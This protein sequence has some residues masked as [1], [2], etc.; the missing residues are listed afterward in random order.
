VLTPPSLAAIGPWLGALVAVL[1]AGLAT[2]APAGA[3]P[4]PTAPQVISGAGTVSLGG[5]AI[6]RDGT[7]GLVFLARAGGV[8]HVYVSR[9]IG[10]SFT[11]PQQVDAA[12]TGGSTQPVI[13]AGNG[14][15]LIVAFVNGGTLYA[16][17]APASGQVFGTP[18]PIYAGAEN[19]TLS[20][21]TFGK[22]YLA[23][24]A[25]E[26]GGSDVR[27]A[28]YAS[29]RWAPVP[30]PLNAASGDDAGTGAGRP[31]V[32]AAGDGVGIVSWGERGHVYA[33][34]I[35][36]TSPSVAVE[37]LDP[38][39][40]AG[41][42]ETTAD[43]ASVSVGGDSS[44]VDIAY[45]EGLSGGGVT[46][47]RVLLSRLQAE[48]VLPAV[49]VDGLDSSPDSAGQP[50]V[51]MN[52]YGRGFATATDTANNSL[53]AETLATNGAPAGLAN[54]GS[55]PN[56]VPPY[57]A[58]APAGLIS[59]LIAWQQAAVPGAAQVLLRYAADGSTLGPDTL[60]SS[61]AQGPARADLGLFAGGD[62]EGDAAVAW[63]QGTSGSL[64]VVAAQLYVPPGSPQPTNRF[65]YTRQPQPT[66][67]WSAAR[68]EWGP[69]TYEVTL[70]GASLGQ[71]TGTSQQVP[72]PLIDGPHSWQL[73]ASNPSGE[74]RN[75]PPA[76]VFVDTTAPRLRA[77]L[78]GTPRA[79]TPLG[80]QVLPAD[81]PP[82]Q[83]G[84]SASGVRSVS[85]T[86]GDRTPETT[87]PAVG[88]LHHA[89]ARPGLYR[90]RATATD[91]ATNTTTLV[92][93]VQ[94]LP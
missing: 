6:A 31:D 30:T 12:L 74:S 33:R 92:R 72:R 66:L 32:V 29:G 8:E 93:Y 60:V 89:Y 7:G 42:T 56:A 54:V 82:G 47:T 16:V 39:T 37:Q 63:V 83:P 26:S 25:A 57:A 17:Q 90:I 55:Q 49:A 71:T 69:V 46:R 86:W 15:L 38:A 91:R 2:A 68:E 48:A 87:G 28:Y 50:A 76:T 81:L 45:R 14:G 67:S 59:N 36:G 5:M 22:A 23:F 77:I 18:Q 80:L 43:S 3:Q 58:P 27:A 73:V 65:L 41:A 13:A 79:G 52:E 35:W 10:G 62:S 84:A 85:V 4:T 61:A 24:A 44:Y 40:F 19:P 75:G 20:M 53:V 88:R 78:T 70:D 34:R 21:S 64:S 51:S 9:L 94:V 1:S 11:G